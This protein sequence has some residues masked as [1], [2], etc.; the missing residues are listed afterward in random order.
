M[1]SLTED[2]NYR[3]SQIEKMLVDYS[4]QELIRKLKADKLQLWRMD[5][6]TLE[7][8]EKLKKDLI[9][10]LNT[11]DPEKMPKVNLQP[12]NLDDTY[13]RVYRNDKWEVLC[14]SDLTRRELL[15]V[16]DDMEPDSIKELVVNLAKKLYNIGEELN[17]R[18]RGNK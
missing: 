11:L 12:R 9:D 6:H 10:Y 3:I 14:A 16:M 8:E 7:E 5:F 4:P 15:E 17:L 2:L 18:G 1:S 13:F